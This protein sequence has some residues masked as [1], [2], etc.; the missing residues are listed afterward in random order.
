[1]DGGAQGSVGRAT[2]G[3]SAAASSVASPIELDGP[4][5]VM[6]PGDVGFDECEACQ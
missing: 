6:R 5:C 4:A 3:L 1:L 2:T